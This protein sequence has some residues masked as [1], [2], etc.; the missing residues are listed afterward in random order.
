VKRPR[1]APLNA[2][3]L[4]ALHGSRKAAIRARL[5]DFR[6]VPESDYFYELLYCLMTPQSSAVNAGKAVE[7]LREHRFASRELDPEP[8]LHQE[9]F[10]IRFHRTKAKHLV[11]AKAQFAEIRARLADGTPSAELRGWLVENVKGLGWK[12]ASHFL[13][14]IGHRDLAI[15][16]RHILKNLVRVGVLRSLPASLTAKRYH[17]IEAKFRRFAAA[18]G[19]PMDELDLLFWSMETG[20]ILK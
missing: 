17:A 7:L 10:Y 19:I 1:P 4:R 18:S 5:R 20:E 12:E 9:E 3:E 14:N 13:R 11:A 15:L 6:A 8:L 16:D 2:D